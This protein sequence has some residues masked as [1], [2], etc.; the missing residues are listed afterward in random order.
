MLKQLP[1]K[2]QLD[3]RCFSKQEKQRY[4]ELRKQIEVE[5]VLDD[6]D[7]RRLTRYDARLKTEVQML[8][9]DAQNRRPSTKLPRNLRSLLNAA[10][11][12]GSVAGT[13]A[14]AQLRVPGFRVKWQS[15]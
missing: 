3:H 13:I 1:R 12:N 14:Y 11:R 9:E 6:E 2:D 8:F 4:R 10:G 7:G 5:A 15:W